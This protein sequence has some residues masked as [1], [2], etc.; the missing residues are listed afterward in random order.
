[1]QV[2]K[3]SKMEQRNITWSNSLDSNHMLL[4]SFSEKHTAMLPSE[5]KDQ[6]DWNQ[7]HVIVKGHLELKLHKKVVQELS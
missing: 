3:V 7:E 1:M 6:E 5:S 4:T 2:R